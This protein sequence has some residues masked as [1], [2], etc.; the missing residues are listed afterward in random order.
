MSATS[1]ILL[2]L[3]TVGI[4]LFLVM[5]V[6]LHAFISLLIVSLFMGI[7]TKMPLGDIVNSMVWAVH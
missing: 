3:V 7:A 5:K 6:K 2:L 1:L 4:L